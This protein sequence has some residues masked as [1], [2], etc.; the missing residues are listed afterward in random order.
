MQAALSATPAALTIELKPEAI[1]RDRPPEPL[2]RDAAD[3]LAAPIADD[4]RRIL[5]E[6]VAAAGLVMPAAL[7]DLTELLRPGLPMV[8]AMLD[9]YRGGLRGGPFQPQLL[10]IG[11]A[12]GRFPD[13]AIA[14]LRRPGSGPLLTVPFALVAPGPKL[15]ELSRKIET[16]LLEK[17]SASLATDR[18]V[19]QLFGVDPVHL[20]YATFNDLAA[21]MRVQFEH[22]GFLPLWQLIE[23]ALYH[24]DGIERIELDAHQFF[25]T[26]GGV[27]TTWTTFDEWSQH[28]TAEGEDA[29]AGYNDWLQT[30]RQYM[31]GLESHGIDVRVTPQ[32]P[33]LSASDNEVALSI[34]QSHCLDDTAQWLREGIED[35]MDTTD[36]AAVITVTEQASERLG[37]F[38]YT[39]LVQ[40]A[41]GQLLGLFNDYPLT[42][43]AMQSIVEDWQAEAKRRDAVFHLE[44]PG[45]VICHGKPARLQPWLDY[46]GSA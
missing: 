36:T 38:A 13:A 44:R 9:I 4:L 29:V 22:A 46:A 26:G 6:E 27:W 35:R 7:Y 5:G 3:L 16:A 34:A 31:A 15:N 33:G 32:R 40:S 1:M 42:P 30:Q 28:S 24:P 17:G 45:Q 37:P 8:E 43:K 23:S 39:V 41:D 19:R 14:P 11:S 12:G 25:A 2:S 10:T 21:L 20:S 18:A